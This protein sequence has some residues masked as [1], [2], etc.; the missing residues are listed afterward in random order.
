MLKT[1]V[2]VISPLR[3][4][5]VG[6]LNQTI[7]SSHFSYQLSGLPFDRSPTTPSTTTDSFDLASR[8]FGA[9]RAPAAVVWPT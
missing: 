1:L 9:S 5:E 3:I 4:Q 6:S 8:R 2:N 7:E